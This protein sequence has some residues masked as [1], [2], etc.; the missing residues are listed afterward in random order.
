[1]TIFTRAFW[2]AAI[3][4]AA[5]SAAGSALL[6]ISADQ[7]NVLDADWANLGGFAAGGALIS[8]LMSIG[9]AGVGNAGPSLATE[10]I[11]PRTETERLADEA[12]DTSRREIVA[13]LDYDPR[14]GRHEA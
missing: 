8:V 11:D 3:E 9:S 6:V 5:K 13:A 10:A 12:A 14:I 4:R 2:L 7:F 1:M